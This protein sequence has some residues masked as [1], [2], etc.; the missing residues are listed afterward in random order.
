VRLYTR[1]KEDEELCQKYS[2][3]GT[4]IMPWRVQALKGAM[5]AHMGGWVVWLL[6]KPMVIEIPGNKLE[7]GYAKVQRVRIARMENIP[8]NIDF[9]RKNQRSKM[10][11]KRKKNGH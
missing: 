8:K 3:S 2:R 6:P 11:M 9:A 7:G 4:K 10:K 1:K 5:E